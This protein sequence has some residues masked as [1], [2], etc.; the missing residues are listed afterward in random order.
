MK[1]LF[2]QN[3]H[4]ATEIIFVFSGAL[5]GIA[6]QMQWF[7]NRWDPFISSFNDFA[8]AGYWDKEQMTLRLFISPFVMVFFFYGLNKLIRWCF[9]F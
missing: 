1:K 2:Y 8:M 7:T 6:S 5:T 9:L 3:T 4:W